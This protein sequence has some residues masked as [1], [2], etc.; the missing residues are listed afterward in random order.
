M[1]ALADLVSSATPPEELRMST[2]TGWFGGYRTIISQEMFSTPDPYRGIW[3]AYLRLRTNHPL[4][5]KALTPEVSEWPISIAG[6]LPEHV[7]KRHHGRQWT[8]NAA[9]Q[10]N[11]YWGVDSV[12]PADEE[13]SHMILENASYQGLMNKIMKATA[14]LASVTVRRVHR[15]RL[16]PG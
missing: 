8:R 10:T 11:W 13:W 1:A 16:I 4:Y 5:R 14:Y 6:T 3:C 9:L 2:S 12:I 15:A 7:G